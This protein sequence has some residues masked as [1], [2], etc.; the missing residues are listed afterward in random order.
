MRPQGT[1]AARARASAACRRSGLPVT[2]AAA[3]S[4]P[5]AARAV[6]PLPRRPA[7]TAAIRL[8]GDGGTV[9]VRL[10]PAGPGWQAV[11]LGG[12][13]P[14]AAELGQREVS[15]EFPAAVPD[16]AAIG[17]GV[18][19]WRELSGHDNPD[20]PIGPE[21]IA[22]TPDLRAAWR[23]ARA[24]LTADAAHDVRDITDGHETWLPGLAETSRRI[25][26][27]A[28]EHREIAARMAGRQSLPVLAEDPAHR[29]AGPAFP[30]GT[31]HHR[32][33]I[34]QPPKPEIPV[35]PWVLER[36]AGRDLDREPGG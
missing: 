29:D 36:I 7:L 14:C 21:P 1:R 26:E 23:T 2:S 5:A 30:L 34:L 28:A 20:D 8:A 35:S 6:S 18:G 22:N 19:T 3:A 15:G 10:S 24:A 33:A 27:L 12:R 4:K 16:L 25:E 31:A 13:N 32:A 9:L 17:C 11:P